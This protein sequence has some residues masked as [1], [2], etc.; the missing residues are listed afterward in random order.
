MASFGSHRYAPNSD[1]TAEQTWGFELQNGYLAAPSMNR[2]VS[3]S[4][5]ESRSEGSVASV[6]ENYYETS[7]IA[8]SNANSPLPGPEGDFYPSK[9]ALFGEEA[10]RSSGTSVLEN[11]TGETQ[12]PPFNPVEGDPRIM[13]QMYYKYGVSE[14]KAFWTLREGYSASPEFPQ[15]RP[16]EKAY[17]VVHREDLLKR[18]TGEKVEEWLQD[19]QIS[20]EWWRCSKCLQRV[21]I[22]KN[23]YVC[24]KC[25]THCERKR[26]LARGKRAKQRRQQ[27]PSERRHKHSVRDAVASSSSSQPPPSQPL[28]V[29]ASDQ[30][31]GRVPSLDQR[32]ADGEA[33]TYSEKGTCGNFEYNDGLDEDGGFQATSTF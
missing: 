6:Q 11:Q 14:E 30:I 9:A 5:H 7:P 17:K 27:D 28:T 3:T 8:W 32:Q 10:R 16:D 21:S 25:N 1:S 19:R 4:S 13:W 23:K 15:V 24:S 2:E 31:E 22:K 18:N 20:T 33:V 26:I 12:L 29:L